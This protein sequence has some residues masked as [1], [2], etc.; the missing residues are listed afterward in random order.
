VRPLRP[1]LATAL[2]ALLAVAAPAVRAVPPCPGPLACGADVD[3]A[4]HLEQRMAN[5]LNY[6]LVLPVEY[7][8]AAKLDGDVAS[9]EPAWGDAGIWSGSYLAAESYRYAVA[10]DHRRGPQSAFWKDQQAQ[11]KARI[12]D[13][14]SQVDLRTYIARDWRP[15]VQPTVGS[16]TPPALGVGGVFP[17]E[18]GMM[19]FSCAPVD[20]PPGFAM[21]RNSDVRGPFHWAGNGRS[22]RL[23]Q[24]AGDYVCEASTTRDAYAG[25]FFGLLNAFDLVGPDDPEVRALIRD[26]VL[27]MADFLLKYGWSYA[28]PH[29]EVA[30]PPF[31]DVYDNALTP[32]MVISPSYRL[33]LSLAAKHVAEVAGPADEALK[34][35]AVW[36]EELATQTPSDAVAELVNDP[37]PQGGY[38]S[39][40]LAH[41][42]FSPLLRL[43]TPA[44]RAGL[45]QTFSM[46][47]RQTSD[48]VNAFFET[49]TYGMGGE[50]ARLAAA[51]QHLRQWRDYRARMDAGG[52]IDNTPRC[53]TA[54]ACVAADEWDVI[55]DTPA[56][57]QRTTIPGSSSR[58][59][60]VEPLPVADRVPA[61]FLWQRSPFTDLVGTI[62]PTHED[63]GIDYLLPYWMLRYLTEVAP[64]ALDPLPVWPGPRFSGS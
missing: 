34:W 35:T 46:V 37:T 29:G 64:P 8:T 55:V 2:L 30:L 27:A 19:M 61:D 24:P 10:R 18:A 4:L 49:V 48:D 3:A 60:S 41:L 13:L 9:L 39:W 23:T 28:H 17:G 15:P 59:R 14:L 52:T 16:G 51:V 5:H 26:D 50:P 40:N 53:A 6:G 7:R 38:F 11:A 21:T 54:G 32:I 12:D 43:T 20:A 1:A 42:V 33:L 36:T 58:Q 25:T 62:A 57:E 31:G 22:A 47:D 63:P 44:E 45:R 56:G